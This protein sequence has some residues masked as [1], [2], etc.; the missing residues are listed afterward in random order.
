MKKMTIPPKFNPFIQSGR[1][2]IFLLCLL[3]ISGAIL[4]IRYD[5]QAPF[6]SL[7][8]GRLGMSIRSIHRYCADMSILFLI[9][10]ILNKITKT[11]AWISGV[12]LTIGW[13]IMGWTGEILPWN[14]HGYGVLNKWISI[15]TTIPIFHDTLSVMTLR[16]D[17]YGYAFFFSVL[18]LH[19][20]LPLGILVGIW[21][22]TF[23]IPR[24]RWLPS[25]PVMWIVG[26]TVVL[27]AFGM[28]ISPGK[29]ANPYRYTPITWNPFYD[30]LLYLKDRNTFE[31]RTL[32]QLDIGLMLRGFAYTQA[33]EIT[34]STLSR[35]GQNRRAKQFQLVIKMDDQA[36][37]IH[38]ISPEK[39][40]YTAFALTRF[41]PP[42]T[43][44]L[45]IELFE[46]SPS[47]SITLGALNQVF[48]ITSSDRHVVW[49]NPSLHTFIFK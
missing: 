48:Q 7:E 10:H 36:E 24:A 28:P 41:L 32:G 31:N 44:R 23:S 3:A 37:E 13:H 34:Q 14:T 38:L 39:K 5:T 18:F 27:L 20:A 2:L 22:H 45:K 8:F 42:G 30:G 33:G 40:E 6:Q 9:I 12:I 4:I 47:Q 17:A 25:K 29:P 46:Y 16:P 43:H 26:I 19:A 1:V 15:L 35:S 21:I 11:R 49:W